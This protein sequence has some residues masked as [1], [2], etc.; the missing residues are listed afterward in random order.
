MGVLGRGGGR[1]RRRRPGEGAAATGRPEAR[2]TPR[3]RGRGAAACC[4]GQ[5]VLPR[6]GFGEPAG[7]LRAGRWQDAPGWLRGGCHRP[8]GPVPLE[9]SGA[10]WPVMGGAGE[11][12]ASARLRLCPGMLRERGG[13]ASSRAPPAAPAPRPR[14]KAAHCLRRQLGAAAV[15]GGGEKVR[16]GWCGWGCG[17]STGLEAPVRPFFPVSNNG[18]LKGMFL[19]RSHTPLLEAAE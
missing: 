7:T 13:S 16:A 9:R 2:V 8:A 5:A 12:T 15:A 14:L 18:A 4:G 10:R 19:S 1:R 17:Y 11:R 3:R 6:A